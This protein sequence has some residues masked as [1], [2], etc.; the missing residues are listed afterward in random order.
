MAKFCFID[1]LTS[2][3]IATVANYAGAVF[4]VE[5]DK[6]TR[7]SLEGV[8]LVGYFGPGRSRLFRNCGCG[9]WLAHAKGS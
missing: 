8:V 5:R 7:F 4:V 1:Q 2:G 9:L 3:G 6:A